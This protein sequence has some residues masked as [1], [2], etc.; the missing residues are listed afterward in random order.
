MAKHILKILSSDRELEITGGDNLLTFLL[1]HGVLLRC[2]CG[3]TGACGKCLVIIRHE[4][5]SIDEIEACRV[6]VKQDLTIEI[7]PSSRLSSHILQKAEAL[8]PVSFSASARARQN[9]SASYG[10]AVDLGTTTIA[11]YLCNLSM[12][13]VMTSGSVKNPQSIYGDDVMSRV[14]EVT[15]RQGSLAKM[16]RL[17]VAAVEWGCR[18][19]A[20]K[21]AIDEGTVEKMVVVGNPVMMHLFLGIHPGGIGV[22]PYRPAF[23]NGFEIK[24]H[25][26]GFIS[27]DMPIFTLPL[28]SGFIG[29]DMLAAA[30]AAE[31][32][33]LPPGTLL[34]DIGTNG[35][36]LLKGRKTIHAASC[37]TGPA[38]EGATLSCGMQAVAGAIERVS[39]M[40]GEQ[41]PLLKIIGNSGSGATTE[42]IGLCGSGII[43]AMAGLHR[44]GIINSSGTFVQTTNSNMQQTTSGKR[45]VLAES[46]AGSKTEAI[47]ISQKDIR[48]IQLGKSALATG[49]EL[50][51]KSELMDTPV[52]I[53]IAG[54]FGAHLD[55]DDMMTLGM[56]PRVDPQKIVIAGNLAGAGAIMALCDDRYFDRARE[57]SNR[58]EVVDLA[59]A[60]DFQKSF[61][62]NL[63]FC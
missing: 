8:L 26:L 19:L 23:T 9:T 38:F 60:M 22:A 24:A 4:N 15:E 3:G 41:A 44:C 40:V 39:L 58:I 45:Y 48:S 14:G 12:G 51:L 35:E 31:I 61:V 43:S 54:G 30:L 57:M 42:P 21:A 7:P 5:N 59:S 27:F 36:I 49:I 52:K 63:R 32:E 2:D 37:A 11:C 50:L 18:E 13:T 62:D 10:I 29:A 34:I 33:Y 16:Q 55:A 47:H 17:V 6:Y 25:A 56:I 28:V 20:G 46:S 53:I 1:E